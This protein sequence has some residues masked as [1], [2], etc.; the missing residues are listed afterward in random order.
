[1]QRLRFLLGTLED[2]FELFPMQSVVR[3]LASL[4]DESEK[5]RIERA[6]PWKS[7]SPKYYTV[8]DEHAIEVVE[9]L[10]GSAFVLGQAA[11]TQA[12]SLVKRIYEEVGKPS[13]IPEG[14]AQIMEMGAPVHDPTGF[15]KITL[16]NAAAN[17]Y[18]H[19]YEWWDDWSG[20]PVSKPTIDIV[21]KL[22]L[23]PKGHHNLEHALR[24][25]EIFPSDLSPLG[26]LIREWRIKL[27]TDLETKLVHQHLLSPRAPEIW[28]DP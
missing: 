21:L 1:M 24:A 5:D 25:L 9:L 13:W 3:S 28:D 12:I 6:D 11:I 7:A 8:E 17:Y 15:R 16:I 4:A 19:R 18:K 23:D 27:A 22:G 2:P 26:Q 10:I 14:K 20:P